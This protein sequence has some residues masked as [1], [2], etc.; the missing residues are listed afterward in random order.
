MLK[1]Q[2][3]DNG[4]YG[5]HTQKQS[6]V[7]RVIVLLDSVKS[8]GLNYNSADIAQLVSKHL[9]ERGIKIWR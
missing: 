8:M 7:R 2:P 3:V 4:A 5:P 1:M 9:Y 6:R